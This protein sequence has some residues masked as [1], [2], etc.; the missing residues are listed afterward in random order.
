MKPS[1]ECTE[2]TSFTCFVCCNGRVN[3]PCW[4]TLKF[5]S[6]NIWPSESIPVKRSNG[7]IA[8]SEANLKAAELE[9]APLL[10]DHRAIKYLQRN[11][12]CNNQLIVFRLCNN[13]HYTAL[14]CTQLFETLLKKDPLKI[15]K[16][17]VDRELK[18][19]HTIKVQC[20]AK[21]QHPPPTCSL[22][23]DKIFTY[24]CGQHS[25]KPGTCSKYTTL[26]EAD[27][28][29]C[30]ELI[31]CSRR[32][33][34]H[35]IVAPCH[36]KSAIQG[37]SPAHEKLD[38]VTG[39]E[40]KI[41]KSNIDYY[42]TEEGMSKC[43]EL[44]SY[45]YNH[46]G[47]LRS[48]V[49]CS[50]AFTWAANNDLELSCE[51][52]V[53]LK[54]PVCGHDLKIKCYLVDLVKDWNPW[55]N[56]K[57]PTVTR[58]VRRLD[59]NKEPIFAY[60]LNEKDLNFKL[61]L[62]NECQLS[63]CAAKF[64]IVRICGH[65]FESSCSNVYWKSYSPCVEPVTNKC[66]KIDCG[67]ET[68]VQCHKYT[69][70]KLANK[71]F[72]C[73]NRLE[74]LCQKCQVN[75]VEVQCCKA[76]FEC[77]SEVSL[78]LEGCGHEIVWKCGDDEDPRLNSNRCKFCVYV[79]WEKLIANSDKVNENPRLMGKILVDIKKVLLGYDKQ[80]KFV[81]INFLPDLSNHV[82]CRPIIINRYLENA[83]YN[84]DLINS[85]QI[86]SLVDEKLY[87][88][89]FVQVKSVEDKLEQIPTLY[90]K[91]YEMTVLSESALS[92]CKPDSDGLVNILV[93]VAFRFNVSAYGEPFCAAIN[94]KGN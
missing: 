18:C 33:C 91:G 16:T 14:T 29:K 84:G 71:T 21:N 58:Y 53:C 76:L 51:E 88:K 6:I 83:R 70:N 22:P 78:V 62:P 34:G 30:T 48:G 17:Q 35:K 55:V 61:T 42:E 75:K 7:I 92:L 10:N 19:K 37:P 41:I 80:A 23:V 60:S 25:I 63:E 38:T 39:T 5:A 43:T 93:G 49:Q 13:T 66:P 72:Y 11:T 9:I 56:I 89:V 24:Q 79:K 12:F 67:H 90:G 50:S 15:C 32:R 77:H 1:P 46:C 40:Q 52:L 74:K 54:S 82:Q 57:K 28:P 87:E 69:A 64:N 73:M 94:K 26:L 85:P 31:P 4:L 68:K 2:L 20:Y 86:H 27:N 8:L 65:E 59:E 45:W 36:L 44:V 3:L 81:D 47:H